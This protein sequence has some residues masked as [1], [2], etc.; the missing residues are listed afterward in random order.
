VK[1]RIALFGLLILSV[2]GS[3]T[4]TASAP[5]IDNCRQTC[6]RIFESE[7]QTCRRLPPGHQ[8]ACVARARE[9]HQHCLRRCRAS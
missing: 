6:N 9:R 3:S 8:A 5:Q 1:V 2:Y 7:V 4:A